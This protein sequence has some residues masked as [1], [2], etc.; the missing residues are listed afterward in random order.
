VKHKTRSAKY[1][2][3][4]SCVISLAGV[5]ATA[6]VVFAEDGLALFGAYIPLIDLSKIIQGLFGQSSILEELFNIS[7]SDIVLYYAWANGSGEIPGVRR[8]RTGAFV[9]GFHAEADAD[10]YGILSHMYSIVQ[11]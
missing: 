11:F 9:A 8:P 4:L 3:T 7:F 1:E 10:V 5:T 2:A 6:Y